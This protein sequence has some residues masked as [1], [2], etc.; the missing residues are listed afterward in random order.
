MDY[1]NNS[2][3]TKL[4]YAAESFIYWICRTL[5]IEVIYS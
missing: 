2:D 5:Y 4:G 3:I 1:K